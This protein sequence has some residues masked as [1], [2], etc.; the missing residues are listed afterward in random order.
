M[1]HRIFFTTASGNHHV[2]AGF[3]IDFGVGN[4]DCLFIAFINAVIHDENIA[5]GPF[6]LVF[7]T[8]SANFQ[9]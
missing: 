4:T 9:W 8:E 1:I 6:D 2:S 5:L 3:N 7:I